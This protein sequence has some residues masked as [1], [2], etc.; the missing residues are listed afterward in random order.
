MTYG[1]RIARL[2]ALWTLGA[3]A[4]LA[5]CSGQEE[6]A[7]ADEESASVANGPRRAEP[8]PV[9]AAVTQLKAALPSANVRFAGDRIG[10]IYGSMATGRTADAAA[11]RF[12]LNSAAALGVSPA[13]LTPRGPLGSPLLRR[14]AVTKAG[15]VGLMYDRATGQY[16]FRLYDYEQQLGGIPVFRAGLRVLVREDGD[17]PV[18]W[19]NTDVRRV[20]GLK[21]PTKL[22]LSS[23]DVAKSL[24]A[25][26]ASA[27]LARQPLPAPAAL[28][29]LST[30]TPTI[31]AGVG[32]QTAT[33]RLAMRYTARAASGP[34]KWTFVADAETGDVLHLE[35]NLHFDIDGSVEAEVTTGQASME[36]GT[37]GVAPLPY[38][39]VTSAVGDSFTDA[40]GAFTIV[41]SGSGSVTVTSE[42]TGEY[43]FVTNA[44]GPNAS[45]SLQAT[46]PSPVNFLHQDT[47]T[48]PE[49]VLAQLNAYKHVNDIRDM[50]LT[51]LPGYPVIASQ[52]DFPINVNLTGIT[53]EQTGGA[54]YDDD[55]SIRSLNFCQS[56][57]ERANTAFGS[58]VHH[59]YGHHII[60]AGGS[61]QAEYGEGMADSIAMLFAKD[62]E[63]GVGYH[64]NQC[65][66]PLRNAA[67]ACQYSEADCSSCGSGLYECGALLS[68]IIWDIWQELEATEPAH[69]DDLIRSLVLSSIPLHTGTSIEPSLAVDLLT[70]DDDDAL[71]ENGTPHYA[72]ICIGFAA[73]GMDCPPIVDGLVVQGGTLDAEG[74]SDG[75]F[76]PSS[77]SY[78]LHHLG[79][80]EQLSYSVVIPP[81]A[82]WLTVDVS[83]GTI[84][85]DG[86]VTVTVSIDQAHAALLPDG[87]YSASI[88]FVNETSGVG[89]VTREA[90]LRVG[91]PVPVY[92]ADF[93]GG[94][95]G[96]VADTEPGNLWH[97]TTECVDSLPGHSPGGALYYGKDTSCD[98]TAPTPIHHTFTSPVIEIQDPL[99]AELG[100]NYL[101]AT[102]ND[103]NYDHADVLISVN[104]GPF[105]LVASNNNGGAKL[106]ET[107]G[108]VPFR[109]DIA[110]LLPDTGPVEIQIQL[111]FNA[112]DPNSNT[113]TGF[114]VDDIVVYA[115]AVGCSSSAECDDGLFCNGVESCVDDVCVPGTP[116]GCDDGVGCTQDS[117]DEATDACVSVP[118]HAVCDDFFLCNGAEVCDPTLG[119]Q[120]G[121]PLVCDDGNEC[122]NDSCNDFFGC[123]F[124]DNTEPCADDGDQCTDDV[125]G[126]GV[127]THPDNG[128]CS[129]TGPFIEVGGMV[130]MEAE[131]HA[132]NI[133]RSGHSWDSTFNPQASGQTVMRANPN[134]NVHINTNYSAT[135]PELTYPVQFTTTGTYYVWIRGRGATADDDSCHVGI[136][137]VEIPT[138]D[139]ISGFGPSLGWSRSTMDGP[140]AT[141]QV[142]S[143]GVHD[144]N[145]WMR[146]DGF[147]VDKIVLTRNPY[148]WPSGHGPAESER[149][150]PPEPECEYDSQCDDDD[151]C[152][153]DTCEAHICVYTD[154]GSCTPSGPCTGYCD[155][156]V[157]FNA[158]NYQSGELGTGVACRETTAPLNGGVCGNFVSPRKLFVN[159]VEVVCNWTPWASI[160]PAE[161]GGYCIHTTAGDYPWAAFATW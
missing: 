137:G 92:V 146:E 31:F 74:P 18:V 73:H 89:N 111:A 108:W 134:T 123:L 6:L 96:F 16:K 80:E 114:A 103:P 19:A 159:G 100:F 69:A 51:Y 76:E 151:D 97:W 142:T 105:Q 32:E 119:C 126:G 84:P 102:E 147:S 30:P 158:T 153:D 124:E 61:G 60:D 160:P 35:S 38:A 79:P 14:A 44:A 86:Q 46:P 70:L 81:E 58:I 2:G 10:R 125:C 143:A 8:A 148:F 118:N 66:Q 132:D 104:G 56:T 95:Q 13:E 135:S 154:N 29:D 34:G 157:A 15:G 120:A 140:V 87:D 39:E 45:I 99:L 131:S 83:A 17:H 26:Q 106:N 23:I 109:V 62:P 149:A 141:L 122:T 94:A 71:I 37:L 54:W 5:S 129:P 4:G 150:A 77:V 121:E 117:C 152:T 72:E 78:T 48:P 138:A 75:P 101:L 133:P 107:R 1:K 98:F 27:G 93:T 90:F 41:E 82:T 59:E 42:I 88:Q 115:K 11:E 63:I 91:A 112:V 139:R 55:S 110:D 9:G 52:T 53:C 7:P 65:D 43:F 116:V 47:S 12:R 156:P 67:S 130:V 127:C 136:D 24:Q 3:V 128:T 49:L 64:R 25:L 50:L 161:N 145:L 40:A 85:L 57:A 20:D 155:N 68:G 21:V 36:C 144:V 22:Q 28:T 33:P 113:N